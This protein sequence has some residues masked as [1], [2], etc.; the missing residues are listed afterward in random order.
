M[1]LTELCE[2]TEWQNQ[3]VDKLTNVELK[4]TM[5]KLITFIDK[6]RRD[7]KPYI[8][9]LKETDGKSILWRGE[10]STF[11]SQLMSS[12]SFLDL[13]K[14]QKPNIQ[15]RVKSKNTYPNRKPSASKIIISNAFDEMSKRLFGIKFRSE[16]I[17]FVYPSSSRRTTSQ[18][19][20]T[21]AFFPK[22][23]IN[24]LYSS[25]IR[26]FYASRL[27]YDMNN[28]EPSKPINTNQE[29]IDLLVKEFIDDF[30]S[31]YVFNTDFQKALKAGNEIMIQC[32][33][34]YLLHGHDLEFFVDSIKQSEPEISQQLKRKTDSEILFDAITGE[35]PL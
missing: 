13:I 14:K 23:K 2:A 20:T 31:K 24:F 25:S 21:Y 32:K 28:F 15:L 19:G 35:I 9:L 5:K 11:N 33:S 10:Q 3:Q 34:Y 27:Y 30:K 26:D 12:E 16:H 1:K 29:Y 4:S 22:G 6:V 7:C 17:S 18:Y 8:N